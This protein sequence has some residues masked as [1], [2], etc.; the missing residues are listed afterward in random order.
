MPTIE[1]RLTALEQEQRHRDPFPPD[2]PHEVLDTFTDEQITAYKHATGRKCVY[3][4]SDPF[5]LEFYLGT[6][7]EPLN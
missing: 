5:L 7:D 1:Q 2:W 3:R 6:Q 4:R